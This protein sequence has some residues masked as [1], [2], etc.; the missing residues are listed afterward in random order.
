MKARELVAFTAVLV[1]V[2]LTVASGLWPLS[3]ASVIYT[4]STTTVTTTITT[5]KTVSTVLNGTYIMSSRWA[6]NPRWVSGSLVLNMTF[7]LPAFLVSL[8]NSQNIST[9][10]P[11]VATL[12]LLRASWLRLTP[13]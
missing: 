10:S 7:A 8:Y 1:V 11:F 5:N 9:P 4:T 3:T 6:V 2:L 12:T 13:A